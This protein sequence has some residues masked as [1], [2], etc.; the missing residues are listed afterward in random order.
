MDASTDIFTNMSTNAISLKLPDFWESSASAWFTQTEV[1][2]ALREITVD[3]TKYYFVVLALGNS[4][5][6]RVASFLTN[7]PEEEKYKT[8]KTHLLIAFKLSDAKRTGRLFP[9]QGLRDNKLSELM[10][11]MLD[12]MGAHKLDFLFVQLFPRQLPA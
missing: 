5:A 10:D 2:F 3:A 4:T 6:T 12:L 9:I 11:R 8:F 7:P 1:Q